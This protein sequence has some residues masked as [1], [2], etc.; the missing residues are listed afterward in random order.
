MA[1]KQKGGNQLLLLA[2]TA[3]VLCVAILSSGSNSLSN[4]LQGIVLSDRDEVK[5]DNDVEERNK[6]NNER[7]RE[8]EKKRIELNAEEAKNNTE[9]NREEE[10]KRLEIKVREKK[11]SP[12]PTQTR[13][14]DEERSREGSE[15]EI[16][17]DGVKVTTDSP[18]KLNTRT[19][20]LSVTS[21]NGEIVKVVVLPDQAVENLA[22][23]RNV[24]I[25]GETVLEENDETGEFEYKAKVIEKKR[26]LGLFNIRL[27]K[28]YRVSSEDGSVEEVELS[29]IDRLLNLISF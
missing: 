2:G 8:E 17:T 12:E 27:N 11:S 9:R 5:E 4:S 24:E 7:L 21:K 25:V 19:N 29:G 26:L 14:R 22:S 10:K 15:F 16:E 18:L 1:T 6:E 20:E 28:E 3:L 23:N 13:E